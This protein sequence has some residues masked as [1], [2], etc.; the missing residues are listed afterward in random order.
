MLP[1][2]NFKIFQ[3]LYSSKH[4]HFS[5]QLTLQL[6]KLKVYAGWIVR[7]VNWACQL[8]IFWLQVKDYPTQTFQQEGNSLAHQTEKV[9]GRS[10]FRRCLIRGS[11][12]AIGTQSLSLSPLFPNLLRSLC[13][14]LLKRFC[15]HSFRERI[16]T[17]SLII[18]ERI[19][20]LRSTNN[21]DKMFQCWPM[22]AIFTYSKLLW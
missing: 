19:L 10:G 7:L 22:D 12:C 11:H 9:R 3:C 8:G 21:I 6:V 4:T 13:I 15:D 5:H 17:E 14:S 20:L 1:K 18:G 2:Q 16:V